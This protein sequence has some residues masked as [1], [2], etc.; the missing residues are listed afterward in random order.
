VL[1]DG[2]PNSAS[3]DES[4]VLEV[5][6]FVAGDAGAVR[7]LDDAA[8]NAAGARGRGDE[9]LE[10][11][12]AAYLE[13]GGEFL[14]GVC[15]RRLVAMGALRHVTD[16]VGEINRMRVHPRFQRRGFGRLVLAR[17][18]HRAGA[19]DF[20]QL[21]LDTPVVPT[22]AQ[23]LYESAGYREVGRGQ[24]AGA[25]V[26]YF[27]KALGQLPAS[28]VLVGSEPGPARLGSLRAG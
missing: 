19:L 22:A 8:M 26:I 17:L 23:R 28:P 24:L 4:G 21:R 7:T 6:R 13:D 12:A 15:D 27:E 5:R 18:E 20:R 2:V 1:S 3:Q 16:A 10:S 9:H 25:E 14:V 11:I